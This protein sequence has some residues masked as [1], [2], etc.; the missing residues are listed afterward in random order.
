M[1]TQTAGDG[2]PF[3]ICDRCKR[4]VEMMSVAWNERA[5]KTIYTAHCHGQTETTEIGDFDMMCLSRVE[6]GIAFKSQLQ[7]AQKGETP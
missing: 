6:P 3:P 5:R 4:P 7:L 2:P 1:I